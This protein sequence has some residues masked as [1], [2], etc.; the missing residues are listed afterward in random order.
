MINRTAVQL[1]ALADQ[2]PTHRL[3]RLMTACQKGWYCS[4]AV[5]ETVGRLVWGA[6]DRV[7]GVDSE[8]HDGRLYAD[9]RR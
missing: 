7:Y 1:R 8:H 2:M 5:A 4:V 6:W 9:L 3:V